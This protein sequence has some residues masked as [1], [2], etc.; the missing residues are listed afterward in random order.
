MLT[1]TELAELREQRWSAEVARQVLR[2]A[3]ASGMSMPAFCERHALST[4][5][6]SWWK[7]RLGEWRDGQSTGKAPR[8]AP[9]VVLG[10]ALGAGPVVPRLPAGLA[11]EVASATDLDPN[12]LAELVSALSRSR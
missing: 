1:A 5:R 12:W 4:Q 3:Q 2:A 7:A 8:L 10:G 11:L 9:A 6:L